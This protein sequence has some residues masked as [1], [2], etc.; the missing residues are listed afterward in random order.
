MDESTGQKGFL[1]AIFCHQKRNK[2]EDRFYMK[3]SST[4]NVVL[5]L[6]PKKMGIWLRRVD[7]T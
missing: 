2:K 7:K 3:F 6:E 4:C 1:K 5:E